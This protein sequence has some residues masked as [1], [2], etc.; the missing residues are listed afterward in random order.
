MPYIVGVACGV[1]ANNDGDLASIFRHAASKNTID[2]LWNASAVRARYAS[3]SALKKD[4]P[5]WVAQG[6]ANRCL[7]KQPLAL[8]N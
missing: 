8:E 3:I 1:R 7:G 4:F 5:A 6:H 2:E